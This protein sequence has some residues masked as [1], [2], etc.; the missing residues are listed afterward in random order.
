MTQDANEFLMGGGVASAS[1]KE[2]GSQVRGTIA[3]TPEV[4]PI[5]DIQTKKP[6]FWDDGQPKQQIR[7]ILQ[8]EEKTDEEDDGRRAVYLKSGMLK[9]V[10]K[11]VRDASAKGL[12]VGGKLA[13]KYVKDGE[14]KTKGFAPPKIYV[15]KYEAPDPMA[16]V[17]AAEPVDDEASESL[18]DF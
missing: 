12:A 10:Q 8:T 5:K 9:A 2:K 14:S 11:A 18:E 7:V 4:M 17:A 15:A 1:F 6:L 16:A 13:I 3:Q